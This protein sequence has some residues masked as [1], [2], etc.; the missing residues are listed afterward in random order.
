MKALLGIIVV[1]ATST[2]GDYIW[3]T[4]GIRHT[5]VAGLT[6]GT[7][8]LA[9][10]GGALGAACGRL[11]KGLPIGAIAGVGGALSYYALIVAV[12]SRTY[13]PAIPAAWVVMWLLLAALDGRWLRTPDRRSW[14]EVA[15]RGLVAALLGGAA[16]ALV[17]NVL[18]GRPPADG[19]NYALQFAAWA[20]AWAPGL[21]ALTWDRV[22]P[23]SA[24]ASRPT[25]PPAARP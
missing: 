7:L 16:F 22:A 1:A 20:V 24:T 17:R 12:D 3:Y 15:W 8:V 10:M 23:R 9:T 2:L 19:R 14:T 11:V 25:A 18:W 5:M 13:G 4:I 21:L 6:Y